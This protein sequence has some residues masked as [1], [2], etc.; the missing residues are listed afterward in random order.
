M[1]VNTNVASL[2]AQ[3]RMG[4]LTSAEARESTRL[5][6]GDRIYQAGFDPSGLAIASVM[7]AKIVGQA[8]AQRNVNDG[9]SMVQVAE[10]TLS[11]MHDM[12]G[13]LMELA[14]AAANDTLGPNERQI[15]A[16]EFNSTKEEYHRLR[17]SAM[18]NGKPLMKGDGS[19]YEFQVGIHND[20]SADRVSYDM[21][22]LLSNDFGIKTMGVETKLKAQ[23]SL[24]QVKEMVAEVSRS[25]AVLGS[26]ANRMGSALQNLQVSNENLQS[27]HSKIRDTDIAQSTAERAI[28]SINKDATAMAL[29]HANQSPS[30]VQRLLDA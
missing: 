3:R 14:V 23:T 25:R 18:F 5:S 27:S 19:S 11:A 21:K 2:A 26:I 6:S 15:L 10:G 28:I 24:S 16:L 29:A 17:E 30:R 20:K 22:K 9:V 8:Q 1:K 13:R 7:K 4:Q 12:G